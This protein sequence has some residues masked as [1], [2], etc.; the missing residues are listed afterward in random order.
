MVAL[1]ID[2]IFVISTN[3]IT[4]SNFFG[5]LIIYY[6]VINFGLHTMIRRVLIGSFE[7]GTNEKCQVSLDENRD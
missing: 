7:I 5:S 2:A 6:Q 1:I 3:F 4:K